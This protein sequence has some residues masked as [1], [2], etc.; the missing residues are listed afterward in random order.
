MGNFFY[1]LVLYVGMKISLIHSLDNVVKKQALSE[2]TPLATAVKESF[3]QIPAVAYRANYMPVEKQKCLMPRLVGQVEGEIYQT[4][5]YDKDNEKIINAYISKNASNPNKT[6]YNM[7]SDEGKLVGEMQLSHTKWN[8][9]C[10]T[11][12]KTGLPKPYSL[13]VT[14]ENKQG[15]YAGVG[16]KLMQAAVEDS[17]K[18]ESSGRLFLMAVNIQNSINDPFIFYR[19]MGL[20]TVGPD[21]L[22]ADP[23]KYLK[24]Y[25]NNPSKTIEEI[26]EFNGVDFSNPRLSSDVKIQSLYEFAAAEKSKDTCS[27]V[28][29]D[30]I[31]FGF[32]EWMY[33]HDDM[34]EKLW[35]PVLDSRPLLSDAN[36]LR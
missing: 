14:L 34:V 16:T 1:V 3:S 7:F 18:T 8:D 13:V 19:K 4:K 33:L 29:S 25:F 20:S 23:E 5:L 35:L 36:R 9:P 32:N 2:I 28:G 30:K 6:Y 27:R 31:Y 26:K 12:Y 24:Y 17:L 22:S 21:K 10:E 15:K 11:A